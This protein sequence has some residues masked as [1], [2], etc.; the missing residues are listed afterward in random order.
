MREAPTAHYGSALPIDLVRSRLMGQRA[1]VL[2]DDA[3]TFG[4]IFMSLSSVGCRASLARRPIQAFQQAE[5]S[6]PTLIIFSTALEDARAADLV[7]DLRA[8]PATAGAVLVALADQDS[9]RERRRLGELG[10]DGYLCKPADR[11]LFAVELL[12]R[13]PRLMGDDRFAEQGPAEPRRLAN[14][15]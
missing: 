12:K 9:K 4:R 3:E 14:V 13:T 1:L 8:N 11:Y 7:V 5:R 6:R 10:C 15:A 2:E